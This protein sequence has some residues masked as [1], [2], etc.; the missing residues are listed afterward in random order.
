MNQKVLIYMQ[1][2]ELKPV[3][4][5]QGYVYNLKQGIGS[6]EAKD[7]NIYFI[8]SGRE[9]INSTK[10]KIEGMKTGALKSVL[11]VVKSI[12]KH[13]LLIY[14][15]NHKALC[16]L[17][18]YDFVH[19]HSTQDMYNVRD[20]LKDYTGKIILTSHSPTIRSKELVAAR[21]EFERKYFKFLYSKMIRMDEYAF[22]KADYIVFPCPEAEEPYYHTWD[23]YKDIKQ[24]KESAYRYVVTGIPQCA[25]KKTRN[26]VRKEC[27]IP[28]DAFVI[29]YIGRHSEIKGYDILK[30]MGEC[31]LDQTEI[32][33]LVAGK[34]VPICGLKHPRWIEIGWTNDPHSYMAAADIFVL[35]NRETYFDLILLE[36]LSLG[37]IIVASRT[38]GNKYFEKIGAKGIFLYDT[39]EEAINIINNI[40][41]LSSEE[42][43]TLEHENLELYKKK[44]TCKAFADSYLKLYNDLRTENK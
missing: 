25:A 39:E 28:N 44:F 7:Y 2:S 34:E 6:G 31:L 16:D 40:R 42:K 15:K 30:E 23:K 35:P 19:F 11:I 17:N 33:I 5:P 29:S 36:A 18:E 13:W 26:V 32:Y 20:S 24:K 22:E 41:G 9:L 4:G 27:G 43:R 21:S 8:E 1:A 38:G 10:N 37:K 14:G 3:G 12:V